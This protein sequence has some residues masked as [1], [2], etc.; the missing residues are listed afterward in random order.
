ML[1]IQ[2]RLGLHPR[3][4]W[5]ALS[6][7]PAPYLNFWGPTSKIREDRRRGE[8]RRREGKVKEKGRKGRNKRGKGGRGKR[9][10]V[11]PIEISGYATA[12]WLY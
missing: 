5:G 7:R 3:T 11:P 6:T 2:F 1:Q 12:L 4:H 9:D 8:D 10:E